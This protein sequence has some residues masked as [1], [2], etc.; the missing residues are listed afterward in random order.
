VA[1]GIVPAAHASD[2]GGSIRIPA[3][4][5]GL[6]GMKP[7]RG[8][9]SFA[10]ADEGWG[11]FSIHHAV[12]WSVRDSAVLLDAISRP[13]PGDPYWLEPPAAP[14]SAEVGRDPGRLR[15]AFSTGALAAPAIDPECAEAVRAAARL[16]E[17]LGHHVEEA[18][19]PGDYAAVGQAAGVVVAA[20]VAAMLDAEGARRGRPI[21]QDEIEP[22]TWAT[23][24]RGRGI[25]GAAYVQALQG[26]HA[27][28]RTM[29]AFFE[30]FD[31]LLMSTL[32]SPA[33]PV[34]HLRCDPS[35]YAERLFAFMPN[36]Q[37]FNVTGQPAMTVPLATSA[38]GLPIGLQFTARVGEEGLL[39]RLAGQLETA[40]PWAG[41]RPPI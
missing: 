29:A 31:V 8:R 10:P 2:G 23:W 14:F 40:S 6:F 34:G 12:T 22:V 33:I 9:V 25:S 11:G 13:Q 26:A 19:L 36:T 7:S 5:C 37:A 20:S 27:F 32:G 30:R 4:A 38:G 39:F 3:S 15:I 28:G 17:S 41:R 1:A 16:C 21:G 24:Q 35:E 18:K